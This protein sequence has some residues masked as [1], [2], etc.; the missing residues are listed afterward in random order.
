MNFQQKL[1]KIVKKNNSF[2]CVGLDSD[3]EKLS[4]KFRKIKDGQFKFNKWIIDQTHDLVCGY[5]PNSAFYEGQGVE[6]IKQLKLTCDY[7]RLHHPEIC[8]ILDYKRGDIGNTNNGYVRFA[9]DFLKSDAVTVIPYMGIEALQAFLNKKDKGIIIGCH[10]SNPGAKEFQEL[11]VS[12]DEPLYL[13]IAQ[14]IALKWNKKGNCM[15]F[16][17]ATYPEEMRKV[18]KIIGEMTILSP[19]INVQGGQ[20]EN[21]VKGGLN[22]KK[23]GMIIN[24]S[25]GIIFAKNPR[26]ETRKLRDEINKYR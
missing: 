16:V 1:D 2:V 15:V 9:F 14:D 4:N 13:K 19:G 3:V 22:S 11:M 26:E 5:K 24:S 17:G 6:G 25:R 23:S 10:S 21:I 18:R 7:I 8:L 12:D 20:V